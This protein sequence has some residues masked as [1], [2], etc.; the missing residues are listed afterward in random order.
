MKSKAGLDTIPL[1]WMFDHLTDPNH[2]WTAASYMTSFVGH[3]LVSLMELIA[4]FY[5][6]VAGR[7]WFLAWWVRNVGGVF[8]AYFL[9]LPWLFAVFQYAFDEGEGGLGAEETAEYGKNAIFLF[10]GNLFIWLN[11]IAVHMAFGDRLQCHVKTL[12]EIPSKT[13]YKKCAL[14]RTFGETNEEYQGKCK[15][16][17]AGA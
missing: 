8:S 15:A 11:S 4:W 17:Y 1:F 14:K 13:V 9:I 7:P 6:Q 3:I 5:Y 12:G 16:Y 10:S 2:G